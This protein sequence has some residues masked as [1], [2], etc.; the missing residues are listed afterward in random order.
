M[1]KFFEFILVII[2][3]YGVY[4]AFDKAFL[5]LAPQIHSLWVIM[6]A[7][8]AAVLLLLLYSLIIKDEAKKNLKETLDHLHTEI[9]NK[10]DLLLKKDDEI[11]RAQ[12]FKED[13]IK[14]SELSDPLE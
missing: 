10:D 6:S 8:F 12:S 13:L 2:I 1:K 9:K 5:I 14:E 11:K 7:L 3:F 4:A